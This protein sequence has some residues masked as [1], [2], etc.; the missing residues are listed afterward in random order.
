MEPIKKTIDAVIEGLGKKRSVCL[1]EDPQDWLKKCLSKKELKHV[2]IYSIKDGRINITADSSSTLYMLNIKKEAMLAA[3]R[4]KLG[5][6]K[7]I[8]FFI[9]EI[10]RSK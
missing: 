6:I 8:R 7:D 5:K 2:K 10:R 4:D 9:G 3:A 1:K